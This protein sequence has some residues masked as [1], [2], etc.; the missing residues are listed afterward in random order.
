MLNRRHFL[1][2]LALTATLA[3]GSASAMD[4]KPFDQKAFEA[5]QAAGKPILVEVYAPWCPVC[6]AQAPILAKLRGDA[7]FRNLVSFNV[8]FD[9]QKDLL[10]KFNVQ[11]QSTLVVFKGKQ[12]A[13]RSTG[14]TNAGSI[15]ALL[16][17]S[18]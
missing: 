6:R 11:K 7:R 1:G 5:A 15:E 2:A 17:K 18:I 9:S 4:K 12:E 14:D 16:A 13:G 3:F 8:D 10:K